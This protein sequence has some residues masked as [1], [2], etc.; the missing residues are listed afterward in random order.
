[1]RTGEGKFAESLRHA[2]EQEWLHGDEWFYFTYNQDPVDLRAVVH[3]YEK[4][5][6][7][8]LEDADDEDSWWFVEL[9]CHAD[10][11]LRAV[12]YAL[13]NRPRVTELYPPEYRV[14]SSTVAAD[15]RF[16]PLAEF[17][18]HAR[19]SKDMHDATLALYRALFER[20]GTRADTSLLLTMIRQDDDVLHT[21]WPEPGTP[22]LRLQVLA[23]R[24]MFLRGIEFTFT[25][26]NAVVMSTMLC[27]LF[28]DVV[29]TVNEQIVQGVKDG[30]F[31]GMQVNLDHMCVYKV[32]GN[33]VTS[34]QHL[35]ELMGLRRAPNRWLY[36]NEYPGAAHNM[37]M[38]IFVYSEL[39]ER[40][41]IEVDEE[42]FEDMFYFTSRPAD[43]RAS[44]AAKLYATFLTVRDAVL[45]DVVVHDTM[46]SP[47]EAL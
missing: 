16:L 2:G 35:G 30:V 19:G 31:D 14:S 26:L 36:L 1:M 38:F 13:L 20:D 47:E 8:G 21:W 18:P 11:P 15:S 17:T 44:L 43:E 6:R 25:L 32:F 29:V 40:Q 9:M 7:E 33:M 10:K 46:E 34:I 28:A 3:G 42:D 27:T 23:L 5:F 37:N 22:P 12:K 39:E 24:Y 41:K 45:T 4:Q